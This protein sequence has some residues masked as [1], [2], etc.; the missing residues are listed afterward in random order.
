MNPNP[1]SS[2]GVIFSSIDLL[3]MLCSNHVT[4]VASFA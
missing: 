3:V 1:S 2:D 4:T